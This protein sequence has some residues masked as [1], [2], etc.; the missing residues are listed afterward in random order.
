MIEVIQRG[1]VSE[2]RMSHPPA[3]AFSPGLIRALGDSL[4]ETIGGGAQ[5]IVVSGLPG[6]FSAGLDVPAFLALDRD[7]VTAAWRDFYELLFTVARS[8]VPIVTAITGHSPAGGAVLALF[9][10]YR[11]MAQ[12]PYKIGL[13]EVQVGIVLPLFMFRA[14]AR[15]VGEHQAERL[16]TSATMLTAAEAREVGFVDEVAPL[17]EV[18][19]RALARCQTLLSLPPTAMSET[20]ANGRRALVE[21]IDEARDTYLDIV[22]RW[23]S[24]E[25]QAA[26]QALVERLRNK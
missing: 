3:N 4:N 18:V 23:H 16:L 8:P 25:T 9:A 11:V 26:L 10:D 17:D 22:E 7:G 19:E 1:P 21:L 14:L 24:D 6:M 2:I 12:G 20:R 5:A 15:L 13:N